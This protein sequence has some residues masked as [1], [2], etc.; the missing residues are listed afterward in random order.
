MLGEEEDGTRVPGDAAAVPPRDNPVPFASAGLSGG[1]GASS[2]RGARP[3][4]GGHHDDDLV[5]IEACTK[6]L[7]GQRCALADHQVRSFLLSSVSVE[8]L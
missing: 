8:Y 6:I 5:G 1:V 4:L 7:E 2:S 3:L